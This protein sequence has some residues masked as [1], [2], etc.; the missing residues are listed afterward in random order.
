M[1]LQSRHRSPGTVLSHFYGHEVDLPQLELGLLPLEIFYIYS[2]CELHV[3]WADVT[4]AFRTFLWS[5]TLCIPLSHEGFLSE[6]MLPTFRSSMCLMECRLG[7]HVQCKACK[8]KI[9]QVLP[10][11]RFSFSASS[12]NCSVSWIFDCIFFT[13]RISE[14]SISLVV[15]GHDCLSNF[16]LLQL[17]R[18]LCIHDEILKNFQLLYLCKIS[19]MTSLFRVVLV[20]ISFMI[21]ASFSVSA[22]AFVFM[23]LGHLLEIFV[24]DISRLPISAAFSV[25]FTYC[26]AISFFS[27]ILSTRFFRN[28]L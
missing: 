22:V 17:C 28:Y 18:T 5:L 27:R 24:T 6:H 12:L 7:S 13:Q 9:L 19:S 15:K 8:F 2:T 26:Q 10:S 1:V 23:S 4:L 16:N 3:L 11:W 14:L 25:V 20:I 21:L